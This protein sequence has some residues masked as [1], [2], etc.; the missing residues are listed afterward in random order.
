MRLSLALALFLSLA[1][2]S[3]PLAAGQ[4]GPDVTDN[5]KRMETT[6]A[7]IEVTLKRVET[8]LDNIRDTAKDQTVTK[9]IQAS[10]SP[11]GDLLRT[12]QN[13]ETNTKSAWNAMFVL[14][15]VAAVAVF[16]ALVARCRILTTTEEIARLVQIATGTTTRPAID[17]VAPNHGDVTG[18]TPITIDGRNFLPRA[19]VS[20]KGNPASDVRVVSQTRITALTPAA[21]TSGPADVTVENPD[22]ALAIRNEAFTY[23]QLRPV[24]GGVAPDNGVLAGNEEITIWGAHFQPGARIRIGGNEPLAWQFLS[25]NGFSA[26]TPPGAAPGAVGVTVINPDGQQAEPRTFRYI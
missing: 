17:D 12:M 8:T 24:I 15:V 20:L 6:M 19:R 23:Y 10:L 25:A 13:V 9:S 21:G 4:T 3:T 7:S 18:G 22:G 16:A 14:L 2:A 5:V 11:G 26:R 1:A